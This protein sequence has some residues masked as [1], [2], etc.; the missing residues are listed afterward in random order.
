MGKYGR[1]GQA[2]G[3]N[4]I[5]SR[6]DARIQTHSEYVILIAFFTATMVTRMRHDVTLYTGLHCVY[7]I[8]VL[9]NYVLIH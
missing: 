3:D 4:V 5:R 2:T 9:L 7:C 8:Y 1:A 6:R